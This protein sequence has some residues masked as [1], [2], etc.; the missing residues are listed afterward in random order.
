MLAARAVAIA[1]G[2]VSGMQF[3]AGRAFIETGTEAAAAAVNYGLDGFAVVL[4]KV[5]AIEINVLRGM[6]AEDL[7]DGVHGVTVLIKSLMML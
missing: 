4:G 1:A 6:A 3:S 7:L 5:L 2:A